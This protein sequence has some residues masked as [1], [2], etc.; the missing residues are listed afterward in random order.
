MRLPFLINQDCGNINSNKYL[1]YTYMKSVLLLS[2]F[3]LSC[4]P[5]MANQ[6]I[7]STV[8]PRVELLS[9][10]FRLAG[11][12]EY[13]MKFA[14]NYICDIHTYFDPYKADP[15]I[16]FAR[17]LAQEKNMGFSKVMFLAVH[18]KWSNNR[19]SLIKEKESNLID[20]WEEKDAVKFVE[21][22]NNFY[23]LSKFDVFFKSH[24]GF[25]ELATRH[26]DMSVAEFDQDW[27]LSYYG[28][29]KVDYKVVLGLGDGGANYGPSVTPIGQK[30][31]VYAVMGSWTFNDANQPIF[32]KE[33]YLTYLIHEF[34]H[35]FV[36]HLL[37]DDSNVE[38]LLEPGG[39]ILLYKEK[40]EM[41]REGYED[42]HSVIN[43][44][45]VRAS[46]VRYMIDHNN[47]DEAVQ[48]E[49]S[50]QQKKG[51]LWTSDLVS[52]LGE[53]QSSRPLYPTF[54]SFYPR[55]ISFFN[56]QARHL[57]P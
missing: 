22:L 54:K 41:K 10:I 26:F 13:N 48:D 56:A 44:S 49:I 18:L 23:H 51:F 46:V 21:L 39:E 35:S 16:S 37:D 7:H 40:T 15:V 47:S 14:K 55:L 29:H 20:K 5:L 38:A 42:W 32:P 4:A 17:E 8:E 2:F 33:T 9:I 27:Y 1:D 31:L 3:A 45:L 36:D 30:K 11:N 57:K 50:K 34:N 12:P 52:L 28:D 25:Y 53:Y 43:E 6:K 24:K 19:F